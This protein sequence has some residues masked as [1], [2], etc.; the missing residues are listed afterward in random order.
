MPERSNASADGTSSTKRPRCGLRPLYLPRKRGQANGGGAAGG[1]SN[2]TRSSG[3]L[4]RMEI[5]LGERLSDKI[6][7][8]LAHSRFGM[9]VVSEAVLAK[10]TDWSAENWTLSRPGKR[11]RV[12]YR[13]AGMAGDWLQQVA[14][15]SP[16]LA[17]KLAAN[18]ADGLE[19][20]VEMIMKA[21]RQAR[22]EDEDISAGATPGTPDAPVAAKQPQETWL[23]AKSLAAFAMAKSSGSARRLLA[24]T[25]G[26]WRLEVETVPRERQ[27][28]VLA[29]NWPG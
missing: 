4:D 12:A 2:S 15:Y 27:R 20:V 9:V 23:S 26:C 28:R 22:G 7:Y 13:L 24:G 14:S 21:M 11:K 25:A 8:G 18:T 10:E 6:N 17:S 16:T 19:T 1:R 5:L 29:G 3:W